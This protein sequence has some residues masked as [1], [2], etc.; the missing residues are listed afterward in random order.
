MVSQGKF[1]AFLLKEKR[2]KTR[3]QVKDVHLFGESE[4]PMHIILM[5]G[6]LRLA[7]KSC[8]QKAGR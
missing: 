4:I 6:R 8:G 1:R 2:L 7:K 3:S 5:Q